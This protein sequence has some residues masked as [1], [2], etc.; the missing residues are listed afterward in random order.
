MKRT[1]KLKPTRARSAKSSARPARKSPARAKNAAKHLSKSRK[2]RKAKKGRATRS[3]FID[4]LV[5]AGAAALYLPTD[6]AW[7]AGIRFNLQL[8]LKHAALVDE[9]AL[10][11]DTDPAPVF[12]A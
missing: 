5:A 8:I 6:P 11:D 10:P 3:D 12:H 9:F 1:K 4:S 7:L 2:V